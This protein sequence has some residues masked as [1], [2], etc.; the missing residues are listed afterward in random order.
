MYV[1]I[2]S[3][4]HLKLVWIVGLIFL[5]V[6]NGLSHLEAPYSRQVTSVSRAQ[7]IGN[8]VNDWD[9][10]WAETSIGTILLRTICEPWIPATDKDALR[11]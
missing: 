7:R 1:T 8:V 4:N 11:P 6:A 5:S 10:S 3:K 2:T 9:F